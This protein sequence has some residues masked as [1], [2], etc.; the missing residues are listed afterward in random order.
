MQTNEVHFILQGKGGVGKS[1]TASYLTQYKAE[2]GHDLYC[3]DT[4]PVNNT[5]SQYSA[6]NAAH[7]PIMG[8][9]GIVD[10]RNF[11]G[12][13]EHI[14]EFPGTA[15]VDNGSSTFLPL[16]AYMV[17]NS[18][19]D[20]LQSHDKRVF[21]HC[22]I[23]GGQAMDETLLGFKKLLESHRNGRIAASHFD[24]VG[25]NPHGAGPL[26][27]ARYQRKA[28]GVRN[29]IDCVLDAIVCGGNCAR[30]NDQG[31]SAGIGRDC[32]GVVRQRRQIVE[33]SAGTQGCVCD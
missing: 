17:E 13:I 5:F 6:F 18:V 25:A 22:L 32:A 27:E 7:V 29:M 15:I 4:D 12:L 19:V 31:S 28:S 16:S 3:A 9:N 21:L 8:R 14:L 2:Q 30:S 23:T 33:E 11:D 10:S 26:R 1:L 20:L 24:V